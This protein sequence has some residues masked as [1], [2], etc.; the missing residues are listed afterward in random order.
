MHFTYFFCEIPSIVGL[1]I[2]KIHDQK[3]REMEFFFAN[4]LEAKF[5]G[6][7]FNILPVE[8]TLKLISR[9]F[10]PGLYFLRFF[11]EIEIPND[12]YILYFSP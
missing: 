2:E 11:R 9:D 5:D 7:F 12:Y 6:F 8:N 1:K 3:T 4:F 10:W